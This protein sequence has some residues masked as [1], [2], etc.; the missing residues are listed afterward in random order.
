MTK[1]E[2]DGVGAAA[3]ANLVIQ[4]D[5]VPLDGRDCEAEL[6]CNLFVGRT[7]GDLLKNLHF[8]GRESVR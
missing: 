8:P 6:A 7:L 4:V 5:E 3:S 2:C 1:S